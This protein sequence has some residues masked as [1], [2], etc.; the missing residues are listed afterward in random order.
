[1]KTYFLAI[2]AGILGA[3]AF[4]LVLGIFGAQPC[5]DFLPREIGMFVCAGLLYHWLR[6]KDVPLK[7]R[8]LIC[9]VAG[10]AHFL[11]LF[12][13]LDI[14][15]SDYGGMPHSQ[16]IPALFLLA[17]YC[18]AYWWLMPWVFN[19]MPFGNA[20]TFACS[21]VILEWLRNF[22][23]T[24][25]P[26]GLWGYSQARNLPLL[27]WAS[28]GGVYL[29][30]WWVSSFSALT[31][32][33][34]VTRKP[35]FLL[36][37]VLVLGVVY[38]FGMH[39]LNK[40]IETGKATN[41]AVVQGNIDQHEKN[42]SRQFS[43]D[44][45]NRYRD[46]TSNITG[47][48]V[49]IWPEAA[50]PVH[51]PA[52][53]ERMPAPL[54]SVPLLFGAPT[55][56]EEHKPAM[57]HNSALWLDSDGQV[58]ARHDKIHLVPFGEYVPLRNILPIDRIVPGIIDFTAGDSYAPIGTPGV[59]VLI[60]YDGVFPEIARREVAEG[61]TWLANLTNDAWYGISS[62]PYQHRDFYVL[63]AVETDRWVVRAA[64]TGLS[65]FI[66]PRG[67]LLKQ[68]ELN[69]TTTTQQAIVAQDSRTAFVL[70]GNWIIYLSLAM[71]GWGWL[72]KRK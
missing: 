40:P 35:V 57:A 50:W 72:K 39:W 37:M 43:R 2:V 53:F 23:I 69:T 59:G 46:L 63:R 31:R 64:N 60:C 21:V 66:D 67:R 70:F 7:K 68:T 3:C 25:F 30:S 33:F 29:V 42:Q 10:L 24:G 55:L 5:L 26:W 41:I 22:I 16:T 48:D 32:D 45:V 11:L 61:A 28:V 27:Q 8:M 15:M 1:V 51:L 36:Q 9:W 49:V 13:W 38:G 56:D 54:A 34:F 17:S 44:I 4:P 20:F 14:A 6:Q 62:A 12:Y 58:L 47:A 71:W 52:S 19:K 18:A 65:V